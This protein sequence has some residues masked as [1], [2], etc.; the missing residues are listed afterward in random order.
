VD[1]G[2]GRGVC[3]R[4]MGMS[5]FLRAEKRSDLFCLDWVG[6]CAV[7]VVLMVGMAI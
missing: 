6:V 7:D 3:G 2:K 1:V 4:E 5:M